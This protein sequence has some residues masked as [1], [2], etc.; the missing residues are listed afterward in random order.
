[1]FESPSSYVEGNQA[2]AKVSNKRYRE[3]KHS[4]Q[5]IKDPTEYKES[6]SEKDRVTLISIIEKNKNAA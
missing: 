1:M 4:I 2:S 5:K 6:D 3:N